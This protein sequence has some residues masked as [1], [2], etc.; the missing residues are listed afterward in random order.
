MRLLI[1]Y[2]HDKKCYGHWIWQC[3]SVT[4]TTWSV[5]VNEKCDLRIMT[6]EN[7]MANEKC[8][9]FVIVKLWRDSLTLLDWRSRIFGILWLLRLVICLLHDDPQALETCTTVIWIDRLRNVK[10]RKCW[11]HSA[12]PS[13]GNQ[14]KSLESITHTSSRVCLPDSYDISF[15]KQQFDISLSLTSNSSSVGLPRTKISRRW[16]FPQ[17]WWQ[18]QKEKH[19]S[20]L[21][22]A[23]I[24]LSWV[25]MFSGP[26]VLRLA[27]ASMPVSLFKYVSF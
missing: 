3:L 15:R 1:S 23:P 12:G 26:T 21:V 13:I 10:Q 20:S 8:D 22:Q 14:G 11:Q 5:V 16:T 18:P 9:L 7:V 19:C 2:C 25:D 27:A 4:V 24:L 17:P 6:F